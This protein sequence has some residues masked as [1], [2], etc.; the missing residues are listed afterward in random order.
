MQIRSWRLSPDPLDR[1]RSRRYG[2]Q[3]EIL[4]LIPKTGLLLLDAEVVFL[5][6]TKSNIPVPQKI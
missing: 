5:L 2:R 4:I 1:R 6:C 3:K